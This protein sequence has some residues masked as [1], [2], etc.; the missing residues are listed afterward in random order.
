MSLK[1]LFLKRLEQA[2]EK[3]FQSVNLSIT[4]REAVNY[5]IKSCPFYS[6]PKTRIALICDSSLESYILSFFLTFSVHEVWFIS[7]E[8]D[9]RQ[10]NL[11][12][13]KYQFK[14]IVASNN[15]EF[16]N[17][18]AC[19]VITFTPIKQFVEYKFIPD[20]DLSQLYPFAEVGDSVYMSSGSTGSPKLIPL[21]INNIEACYEN[22]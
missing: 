18:F 1:N 21:A 11:L 19:K 20:Y 4:A 12:H 17:L 14:F 15:S 8:Y 2:S 5:Y 13:Q 3:A 10:L 22:V 7:A 16:D 9:K 6:E